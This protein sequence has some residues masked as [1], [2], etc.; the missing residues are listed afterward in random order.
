MSNLQ[1]RKQRLREVRRSPTAT[2]LPGV[3]L[4]FRWKVRV[5]SEFEGEGSALGLS[6]QSRV[7]PTPG[8]P[9]GGNHAHWLRAF[10]PA[11]NCSGCFIQSQSLS[12]I[13]SF[14]GESE[15]QSSEPSGRP[16]GTK[17]GAVVLFELTSQPERDMCPQP[18]PWLYS[19]LWSVS[20]GV[21]EQTWQ[22]GRCGE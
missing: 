17:A 10:S 4:G 11:R 15:T 1:L 6:P 14:V 12:P 13:H 16:K 5:A 22:E 20:L 2:Q 19:G 18:P 21:Q 9:A 3:G 7:I 8:D